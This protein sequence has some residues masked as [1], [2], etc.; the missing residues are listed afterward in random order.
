MDPLGGHGIQL[1]EP[2]PP[3]PTKERGAGLTAF[4][5]FNAIAQMGLAAGGV[6]NAIELARADIIFMTPDQAFA[7]KLAIAAAVVAFVNPVALM[8]VWSWKEWGVYLMLALSSVGALIA[9]RLDY[10]PNIVANFGSVL[11]LLIT[12]APKW[13]LFD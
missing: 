6:Y 12:A 8:G 9:I 5:I 7:P 10:T 2:P 1:Y 3:R 4:L 11:F 13:A